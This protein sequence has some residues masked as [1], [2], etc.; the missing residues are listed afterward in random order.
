MHKK[1]R[2]F[3][4]VLSVSY[5]HTLHM[6]HIEFMQFVHK[7]RRHVRVSGLLFLKS[8]FYALQKKLA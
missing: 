7:L 2:M 3:M 4:Q 8:H 5:I 1:V 6:V